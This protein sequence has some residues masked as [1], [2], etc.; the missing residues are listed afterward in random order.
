MKQELRR[1]NCSLFL[2]TKSAG[3]SSL[4]GR[5]MNGG[6]MTEFVS[7]KEGKA[8]FLMGQNLVAKNISPVL[9]KVLHT[10]IKCVN[11]I[12]ASAKCECLFK[13]FCEEQNEDHVRLLLHTEPTADIH[14]A[15]S[16]G[17]HRFQLLS[18]RGKGRLHLAWHSRIRSA[19]DKS[20]L[21]HRVLEGASSSLQWLSK[22]NYL[23]RLM[24]LF[25]TF[26]DF[27][28]DKPEMK[29]LLTIDDVL[30]PVSM[31][32]LHPD[33]VPHKTSESFWNALLEW[34][35]VSFSRPIFACPIQLQVELEDRAP[36]HLEYHQ[37]MY[38]TGT[39]IPSSLSSSRFA[40]TLR[41]W[42]CVVLSK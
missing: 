34:G 40:I 19:S 32:V 27:L 16:G 17:A 6:R 36:A 18:S 13:L 29:H 20:A 12:K 3:K 14:T 26:S 41:C 11:V 22:G 33:L 15:L 28:N 37:R 1:N 42:T 5:G 35:E 31:Q 21:P 7:V 24:E 8:T 2:E 30:L 38:T 23:K 10:V 25:D 39:S 9:N 4:F